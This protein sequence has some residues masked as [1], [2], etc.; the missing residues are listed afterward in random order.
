MTHPTPYQ[1]RQSSPL[2]LILAGAAFVMAAYMVWERSSPGALHLEA[3]PRS[4]TPRGD[5]ADYE[6]DVIAVY[7]N[8]R[9][10]VVHITKEVRVRDWLGSVSTREEGTGSGFLWDERGYVVTNF[11]VVQGN[12]EMLVRMHDQREARGVVVGARPD[13]DIA[14]LKLA[15]TPD[16]RPIPIGTSRDLKVGQTVLAIGNP[17]GLDQTATTGIISAL[18]RSIQSVAGSPIRGVI[19]TDAAINPGNSGGPLLDSAGRL[20]GMNTAIKSPSG[21]S[22]GIGFAVPVDTINRV[23]PELIE[24]RS[25]SERLILGFNPEE[26]RIGNTRVVRVARVIPG[27]GAEAAGL[28]GSA[29]NYT[30]G[31]VILAVE[32]Q[33]IRSRSDIAAVLS[34][35]EAGDKVAVEVLRGLPQRQDRITLHIELRPESEFGEDG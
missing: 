31:D 18:D 12:R 16:L 2:P 11:H 30:V 6:K 35:F 14:V 10:S 20:I 32:G 5:L 9:P 22:A 4:V 24:G 34:Q 26:I 28:R 1:R 27:S 15:D 25:T 7:E 33:E 17:Y 13:L 3:E 29:A 8:S 19:Q 23:V 21:G